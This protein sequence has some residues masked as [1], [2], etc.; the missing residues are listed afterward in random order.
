[1]PHELSHHADYI[2]RYGFW[3]W[4]LRECVR[5]NPLYVISAALLAY[6]VMQLNTEID[7]QIGKLSGIVISLVL[8]HVYEFAVLGAATMVLT[9]R[10]G[11]GADLHGLM[12]VAGLFVGGSFLALDELA[13]ISPAY[14][15]ILVPVGLLLVGIKAEVYSRLPG[16]YLPLSCK[17]AVLAIIAGHSVSTLLG[18]QD[19][20]ERI[21]IDGAQRLAWLCGWISM[22]PILPVVWFESRHARM[23]AASGGGETAETDPL[24]T[25][26][27]VAGA[28]VMALGTGIAH[29]YASDWVFDR[30]PERLLLCPA[31][32]VLLA[33]WLLLRWHRIPRFSFWNGVLLSLPALAMQWIWASDPQTDTVGRLA[34][35]LCPSFQFW[36]ACMIIYP[37][38]ALFTGRKICLAGLLGPATPPVWTWLVRSRNSIPHFRAFVSAGLG[39]AALIAGM[40][41]SLYRE[42]LLKWLDPAAPKPVVDEKIA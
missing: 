10:S 13:A 42:R 37:A 31:I 40:L 9:R 4:V 26:R 28:I 19:V 38:L 39:F 36:A 1:M 2:N 34:W 22:L 41:V 8:L 11:G 5:A 18:S 27:C 6:G 16:I 30:R 33:A 24:I 32:S 21:G 14:G 12:L 15:Y 17:L 23:R 3:R 7:P 25:P 20:K 35:L 29:L